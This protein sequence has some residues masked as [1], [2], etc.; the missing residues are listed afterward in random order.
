MSAD[1]L[2]AVLIVG[3]VFFAIYKIFDLF[4]KR[5]ERILFT[6]KISEIGNTNSEQLSQIIHELKSEGC[7]FISLR[8]GSILLGV[9]L[10]SFCAYLLVYSLN[11]EYTN[12][13]NYGVEML[14]STIYGSCIL[15]FGGLSLLVSFWIENKI[16]K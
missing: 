16:K 15:F 1:N 14:I 10:G 2:S 7:R 9:G 8:L 11:K 13:S 12:M 4:V 5:K 3:I 6:E